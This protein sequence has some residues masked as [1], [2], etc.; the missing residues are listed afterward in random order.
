M[1]E[2]LVGLATRYY[3]KAKT[4]LLTRKPPVLTPLF[5]H[6]VTF[7]DRV[8]SPRR[9][10]AE[11][12][13]FNALWKQQYLTYWMANPTLRL[14]VKSEHPVAFGSDDHRHPRGTLFDNSVNYRFRT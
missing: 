3:R 10:S 9:Q 5:F 12:A 8:L 6:A 2:I 7:G 13:R 11:E 4:F 14:K 1:R